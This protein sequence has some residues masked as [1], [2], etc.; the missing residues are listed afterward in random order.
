MALTHTDVPMFTFDHQKA[1]RSIQ[2]RGLSYTGLGIQTA[3]GAVTVSDW[4]R[5]KSDPPSSLVCALALILGLDHLG[6]L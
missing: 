5:G 1:H 4:L 3:R 6:E 2:E